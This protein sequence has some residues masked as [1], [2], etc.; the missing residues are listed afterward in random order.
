M[1]L[2]ENISQTLKRKST[3]GGPLA[4]VLLILPKMKTNYSIYILL[5]ITVT[6]FI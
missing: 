1:Q 5:Y 4:K 3:V 2:E 6:T